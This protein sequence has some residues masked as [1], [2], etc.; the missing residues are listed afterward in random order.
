MALARSG[1]TQKGREVL[2]KRGLSVERNV[3]G[4]GLWI[5][6]NSFKSRWVRVEQNQKS[7]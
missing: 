3:T 6:Q 4:T 5:F 7:K 2:L 1:V